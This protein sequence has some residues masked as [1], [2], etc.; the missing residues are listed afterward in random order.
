MT[1]PGTQVVSRSA[2]PSRGGTAG[3]GTWHIA[4]LAERGPTDAPQMV[5]SL[6]EFDRYFGTRVSYGVRDSVETFFRNGGT[7]VNMIR[8]VGPAAVKGTRAFPGAAAALSISVDSVGEDATVFNVAIEIVGSQFVV[9]VLDGT[10]RIS[11]SPPLNLPTDAVAWAATNPYVRIRA[12]GSVPPIVAASQALA[13]GSDDRASITDSH[14]IAALNKIPS[15]DGPGQV[16]IPGAITSA[17]HLGVAA[18]A[19]ANNR[20]AILDAPD[21]AVEATLISAAQADQT[22]MSEIE[23]SRSFFVEGWHLIPGLTTGTTRTVPPSSIVAALMAARDE[24]TGNPNEPAAGI[25]GQPSFSLGLARAGWSDAARGRLNDAAVNVF[26]E[27]AGRQRLYGYRTMVDANG[28]EGAWLGAGNARLRMAIQSEADKRAEPFVFSQITPSKIAEFNGVLTGML[29]GYYNVGA[30]YGASPADAFVVDTGVTV[31]TPERLA[32]R[33]MS[34]VV[35]L[36]M[37]EF[38]EIVYMEFVKI[39]F[40]EEL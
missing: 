23:S 27:I 14:R 36:R 13:G 19:V 12:T 33:Q 37:N 2:P 6:S 40:T 28:D 25:N 8:V 35:G 21:T 24:A 31:N 29:L 1:I 30:L 39:P 16:S 4:A 5:R 20:F 38:A 26:R 10:T 15:S 11:V 32:A 17:A 7:A 9:V 34:A 18:H 22:A 3:T